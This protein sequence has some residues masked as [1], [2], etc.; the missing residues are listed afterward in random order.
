M[1]LLSILRWTALAL[2]VSGY[3][4]AC[5][6]VGPEAFSPEAAGTLAGTYII[7]A[8]HS[9]LVLDLPNA[10]PTNGIQL[11][12]Y[13][14]NNSLAQQWKITAVGGGYYKVTSAVSGNALDVYSP[15]VTNNGAKIS[16]WPYSGKPYQQWQ[17][18]PVAGYYQFVNR[19]SGKVMDVAGVSKAQGALIQ[20][21]D[22]GK[23]ANQLWSLEKVTPVQ[24]TGTVVR[25]SGELKAALTKPNQ[26]IR[27]LANT[28]YDIGTGNQL[29]TGVSVLGA[30]SS[31]VI[32]GELKAAN[33]TNL[34]LSNFSLDGDA[35][36]YVQG[37]SINA[38]TNLNLS[39]LTFRNYRD[40]AFVV[41]DIQGGRI[42]KIDVKNCTARDLP[43]QSIYITGT[44][45]GLGAAENVVVSELAVDTTQRGGR[46]ID[47][48]AGRNGLYYRNVTFDRLRVV[49]RNEYHKKWDANAPESTP[50]LSMELWGINDKV[51]G[52]SLTI[53]NSYFN[54]TV[55]VVSHNSSGNSIQVNLTNTT[56][57]IQPLNGAGYGYEYSNTQVNARNN[58]FLQDFYTAYGDYDKNS[59]ASLVS[60]GDR[61]HSSNA[62]N[63]HVLISDSPYIR[64]VI[65]NYT[66]QGTLAGLSLESLISLP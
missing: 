17:I 3:L 2:F 57:D 28:T 38:A 35:L 56:F 10:D 60:D 37:L 44:A 36:R 63:R 52:G 27:L 62:S 50:E 34:T 19:A 18:I 25:N 23:G 22:N 1:K 13:P 66:L 21:W 9:G 41:V 29:A 11:W 15:Q 16:L 58:S 32:K 53:S 20:Q 46:G 64:P 47:G 14:R 8:Q 51:N 54:N 30:G 45:V 42:S 6:Q 7:T 48:P 65:K 12:Q 24:P 33:V 5:N 59:R 4:S 40:S 31:S 26:T 49:V 43:G 61:F 55:S 39:K